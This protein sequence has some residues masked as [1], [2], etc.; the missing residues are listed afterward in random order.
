[1]SFEISDLKVVSTVKGGLGYNFVSDKAG[2][3]I[4]FEATAGTILYQNNGIELLASDLVVGPE[5]N[6]KYSE[7]YKIEADKF[8]DRFSE[9]YLRRR[10]PKLYGILGLNGGLS[11]N[12]GIQNGQYSLFAGPEFILWKPL[13]RLGFGYELVHE[14]K[15][16][17]GQG[18]LSHNARLYAGMGL[19]KLGESSVL[20]LGCS[21]TANF[22]DGVRKVYPHLSVTFW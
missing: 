8:V 12:F 10:L 14:Q 20:N 6:E 13:I 3:N 17:N 7:R 1:M 15:G 11:A 2:A 16:Q 19:L 18:V 5:H 21:V 22:L 9:D 4:E